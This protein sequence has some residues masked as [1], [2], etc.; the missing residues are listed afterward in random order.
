MGEVGATGDGFPRLV[1]PFDGNT[2]GFLANAVNAV[3]LFR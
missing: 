2:M 1:R 3:G